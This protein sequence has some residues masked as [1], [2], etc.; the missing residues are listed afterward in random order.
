MPVETHRNTMRVGD[1]IVTTTVRTEVESATIDFDDILAASQVEPDETMWGETPWESCDGYE[2]SVDKDH[3]IYSEEARG[4]CFSKCAGHY[5]NIEIEWDHNL[6]EWYR[7]RGATKQVAHEM[8]ALSLRKRLDTLVDWYENGWEWWSVCCEY[9]DEIDSCHGIDDHDY[10]YNDI[11]LECAL[12]VAHE[13][14][15]AGYEVHG[16]PEYNDAI[17][18]RWLKRDRL[19]YNL[20]LFSWTD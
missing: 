20:R 14:E 10:A 7:E 18:H 13:L 17:A 5:V 6:F 1:I 15:Q 4:W 2:H 9:G 16:R 11:R 19:K 3:D 12:N 8:V